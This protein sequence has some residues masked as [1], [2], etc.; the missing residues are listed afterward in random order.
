MAKKGL[1]ITY[2]IVT[3]L[4]ALF[5]LFSGVSELIGTESGNA[6]MLGLGYPL[7]M[8]IILGVAKILGSI[9]IIQTKWHVIKEWAYAGFSIDMIGA[10]LSFAFVG[11]GFVAVLM[12]LIF[13]TV[14]FISYVLWKKTN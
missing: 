9:A 14:M 4:F 8:N 10:T 1:K 12:P 11:D 7:Y 13:L 5:M 6:V 2:W 3:L